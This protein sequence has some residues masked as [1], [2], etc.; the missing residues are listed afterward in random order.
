MRTILKE[1]EECY[2]TY[3]NTEIATLKNTIEYLNQEAGTFQQD[4]W[5]GYYMYGYPPKR[6]R[7][8]Q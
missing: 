4:K 5:S 3:E 8:K 6:M 1:I 7:E 2:S